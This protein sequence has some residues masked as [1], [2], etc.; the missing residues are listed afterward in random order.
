M[1]YNLR[2]CEGSIL[3]YWKMVIK[4]LSCSGIF[5][6]KRSL[7]SL[8]SY[9]S[10]MTAT[11]LSPS[12]GHSE[13]VRAANDQ[14]TKWHLWGVILAPKTQQVWCSSTGWVGGH[15]ALCT[16]WNPRPWHHVCWGADACWSAHTQERPLATGF[17]EFVLNLPPL[18]VSPNFYYG[19][20]LPR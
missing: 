16:R 3:T 10:V 6:L 13:G 11:S 20:V 18:W 12:S 2:I 19:F 7:S 8:R 1:I 14:D 5:S 15:W 9:R 4:R 17:F